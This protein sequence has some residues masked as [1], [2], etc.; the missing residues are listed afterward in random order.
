MPHC[1][2]E[3]RADSEAEYYQR[4]VW[5]GTQRYDPDDVPS[6]SDIADDPE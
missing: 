5:V 6:R 3:N 1:E 2:G 4:P